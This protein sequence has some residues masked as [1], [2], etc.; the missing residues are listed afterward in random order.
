MVRDSFGARLIRPYLLKSSDT[1]RAKAEARGFDALLTDTYK[2]GRHGGTGHA[3]DW[4]ICET[5]RSAIDPI[6]L[7]LSGGLNPENVAAA[8]RQVG[9]FAVD[10]S[11]GVE[12]SPGLKSARRVQEFVRNAKT[13]CG[14]S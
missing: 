10:A 4:T 11:S 3:C 6:P 2:A 8:I 9:P 5:I 13:I 7:V 14:E 12:S 1:E